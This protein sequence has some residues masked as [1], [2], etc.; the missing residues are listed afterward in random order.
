MSRSGYGDDFGDNDYPGLTLG[1]FVRAANGARGQ[2]MLRELLAALDAMP[3]K[4]LVADALVSEDGE[5]CAL[6]VLGNARGLDMSPLDPDDWDAVA[7]AF[8]VAP[9][10]VREIVEENDESVAEQ[11][12]VRV[13]IHGPMRPR[14]GRDARF[15]FLTVDIP[16]KTVCAARWAHM[17]A[18]TAKHIK[19]ECTPA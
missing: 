11:K 6:G 9:S 2:A 19:S 16:A 14:D 3:D 1:P 8:G 12:S 18:W 4:S 13:A 15:P 10:L 5:F 17:R 7:K